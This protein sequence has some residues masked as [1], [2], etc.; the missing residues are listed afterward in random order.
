[1]NPVMK[2]RILMKIAGMFLL[3]AGPAA[4]AAPPGLIA[5][6]NARIVPVS[7]P[8][9]EKGTL[10]L[11]DGLIADVGAN[12]A[13]PAGAWVID[14]DGLT[15]YPGLIDAISSWG[16]PEAAPTTPAPGGRGNAQAPAPATPAT[17][18]T[19]AL[20]STGPE[21][22]PATQSW[23]RA[24]DLV[25]PTDRR[26]DAAR[27]AGYTTAVTFPKQGIVAGEGAVV[28]LGGERPGQMVVTPSVGLYLTMQT[29]GFSSF[30]GSL[31][32][33]MA[34]LRQ[35]WID[36]D[37]YKQAQLRYAKNP[38][39]QRRPD[40]DRALEGV[41]DAPRILLPATTAVQIDRMIRFAG[42]L[43]T[44]T[45]LYGIH[46]GYRAADLIKKSGMPVVVSLRW[47]SKP[48]DGDPDSEESLRTLELRANAP[49]TPAALVKAGV[50][51]AF[52]ADGVESP[53]EALRSV[54]KAVD[55]GLSREDAVRALTLSAAEIYGVADRLGSLDRGKIANLVLVKG[56]LFDDR[57]QVRMIF[58]DGVKYDPAPEPPPGSGGGRPGAP[59]SPL[60][61]REER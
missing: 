27:T 54:K 44:P 20:R 8:V 55:A 13:V 40:Y 25:R 2:S 10:V 49:S 32:G 50:K 51:F 4:L 16:I 37:Y 42:D 23:L 14:G 48:R 33:V 11:R 39:G 7:G 15:V 43:K 1:M 26:L 31:F 36:A 30:P 38:A 34:Y 29:A 53:R 57:A 9:I 19:P 56:D 3:C 24:A 60:E 45:V 12:A 58:I 17:P 46:D 6:R 18:A 41:L 61:V 22:R 59:T 5:I 47:P 21:D 52:S 35:L 28:N